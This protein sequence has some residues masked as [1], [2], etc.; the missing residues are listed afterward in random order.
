MLRRGRGVIAI[1]ITG[2]DRRDLANGNR[3]RIGQIFSMAL[4]SRLALT[5]VM[6][7][8]PIHVGL[9]LEAGLFRA[10]RQPIKD[11]AIHGKIVEGEKDHQNEREGRNVGAHGRKIT[12]FA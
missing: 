7:D 8:H 3:L 5:K 4:A 11:S 12:L 9:P 10:L 1:P 6:A 2:G